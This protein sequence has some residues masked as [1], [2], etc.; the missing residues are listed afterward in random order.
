MRFLESNLKRKRNISFTVYSKNLLY[1]Y[2]PLIIS[3]N[4]MDSIPTSLYIKVSNP[5][6]QPWPYFSKALVLPL[7]FFKLLNWPTCPSYMINWTYRPFLCLSS[8]FVLIILKGAK[9]WGHLVSVPPQLLPHP[10]VDKTY[11]F[12]PV[13]Q[14]PLSSFTNALIPQYPEFLVTSY[15]IFWP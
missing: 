6:P 4:N 9:C 13:L 11:K 1:M 10:I 2:F 8:L 14:A 7:R 3:F 12:Y 15:W 5:S